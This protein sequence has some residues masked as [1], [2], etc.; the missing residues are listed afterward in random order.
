M[1]KSVLIQTWTEFWRPAKRRRAPA[2]SRL[3][4]AV[5]LVVT[6]GLALLLLSGLLNNKLASLSWWSAMLPVNVLVCVSIACAMLAIS[7]CL[8]CVLQATTLEHIASRRDWRAAAYLNTVVVLGILAGGAAGL[9]LASMLPV[10]DAKGIAAET[11]MPVRVLVFLAAVVVANCIAERLHMRQRD[12]QQ[13]VLESR[14]RLMQAQVAPQFLF[15]T[16]AGVQDLIDH[17]PLRARQMLECFTD[18]LRASLSQLRD[19]DSSLAAELETVGNYLQLLRI[20]TAEQLCFTIDAS[21][22]ARG[23][24]VPTLLVQP[25]V[26]LAL[27]GG[28]ALGAR[29]ARVSLSAAVHGERLEIGLIVHDD[30]GLPADAY[31]AAAL[32]TMHARLAAR[33]GADAVLQMEAVPGGLN[34]S[35]NLPYLIAPCPVP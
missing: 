20:R 27:P 9:Q 10:G 18:H 25:L 4:V 6:A 14:L 33:Y 5:S 35:L 1:T 22:K 28:N 17:E 26:E 3:M 24:S 34:I 15:T 21:D 13:R 19:T 2:W 11:G 30:G 32:K 8:E 12:M 16:L 7:R 23:A 29:N 31:R